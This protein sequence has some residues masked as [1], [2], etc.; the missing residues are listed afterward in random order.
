[1]GGHA[2]GEVASKLAVETVMQAWTEGAPS[3]PSGLRT[4]VRQANLSVHDAGT[5]SRHRGMGTTLTALTL[6]GRE[7]VIAHVGD[8][9]AYLVRH[10]QCTQLTSD[11]SRVAELLRLR[12]ISPEHAANHPARSLLTRSLA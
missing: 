9:R 10:Q 5:E 2:A 11:H 3:P 12:L 4:A 8:S 7:A 6:A 1:M